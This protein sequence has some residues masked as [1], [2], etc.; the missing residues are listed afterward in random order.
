VSRAWKVAG[1]ATAVALS[2]VASALACGC[3]RAPQRRASP[4]DVL[5]VTID[6]LRADHVSAYGYARRTSPNLDR[7]AAGGA[8]FEVAYAPSPATTP[9]H[10]TLLTSR[11]PFGHGVLR[12]GIALGD[13]VPSLPVLLA[14]AGYLTAAFVS[15]FPV[16]SAFGLA[17]GFSHFDERFDGVD[18]HPAARHKPDGAEIPFAR[19]AE[20]TVDAAL[21]WLATAPDSTP[22]FV[23]VHLFD[24]HA[25]YR[26]PA[27]YGD[28]FRGPDTSREARRIDSYDGEILYADW[29]LGRL[30]EGMREKAS[31]AGLL[32]VV[33][34]D[35][36]E[37]FH[38]HGWLGHNRSVFEEEVRIPLVVSWP[39]VIL[40]G[41]RIAETVHLIDVLPTLASATRLATGSARFDGIDLL[42]VMTGTARLDSDRAVF[43]QRPYFEN[44]RRAR[45]LGL[46]GFELAARRGRWKYIEA[47][48]EGR[49]NLFDLVDDPAERRDLGPREP[50]RVSKLAGLVS[51]WRRGSGASGVTKP[52][53]ASSGEVRRKLRALGYAE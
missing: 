23:W 52:P 12:N 50:E 2:V 22:R 43:L 48:E 35:H 13:E 5:L 7:L 18:L 3:E 38:E 26:A 36:G 45:R 37:A 16:S 34:S 1:R 24:P 6:T 27:P 41:R 21:D 42:P 8:L 40:P 25:P 9:S 33:T 49:T 44:E 15:S 31:A 53:R 39:G 46:I 29:H 32:T 11:Y 17:R 4:P 19:L 10:A 47:A 14:D 20:R 30:V 28:A 51:A